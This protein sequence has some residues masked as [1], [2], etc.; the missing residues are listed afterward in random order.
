ME[1]DEFKAMVNDI[2]IAEKAKGIVSYDIS[3]NEKENIV[4][5][6]SIFAVKDIEKGNLY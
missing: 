3:E 6:R 1:P 5:R 2:R 4:F